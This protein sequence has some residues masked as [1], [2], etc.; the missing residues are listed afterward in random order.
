MNPVHPTHLLVPS[1]A[2]VLLVGVAASQKPPARVNSTPG[3]TNFTS[4]P[5]VAA[6]GDAVYVVWSD[7]RNSGMRI[8]T[9]DVYFNKSTDGGA[10]WLP[11]DIRLDTDPGRALS[12]SPQIAVEGDHVYVVWTDYRNG[13]SV[14][15]DVYFNRSVDGGVTWLAQD[16]RINTYAVWQ[17]G[18][19]DIASHAP[20]ICA[21]GD[22][23]FIA[24]LD[25][26]RPPSSFGDIFFNRSTDAGL[27]WMATDMRVDR[28]P[29]ATPEKVLNPTICCSGNRVYV[30]WNDLRNG[31]FDV[32]ANYSH[33]S[34]VTFAAQDVRVDTGPDLTTSQG[35]DMDCE[36]DKVVL[37]WWDDRSGGGND[38]YLNYSTDAAVTFQPSDIR[39][40]T[41]PPGSANSVWPQVE[42]SGDDV[43]VVWEDW[44]NGVV[45][46]TTPS[47]V[48]FS[49]SADCGATWLANDVQV[50]HVPVL[51][52]PD[53]SSARPQMCVRGDEVHVTWVDIRN[54]SSDV[55]FNRSFNKGVNW[56]SF[57]VRMD[58]GVPGAAASNEA[59]IA[60]SDRGVYVV[61]SDDRIALQQGTAGTDIFVNSPFGAWAY[62]AGLGGTGGMVPTLS[63]GG[64]PTPGRSF[65]VDVANGLGAAPG[66][67]ILGGQ[68]TSL[69]VSG[70]MLQVVPLLTLPLFLS[71]TPGVPGAGAFT[72]PVRV[73]NNE[74]FVGVPLYFQAL[75]LDVGATA[76]LSMTNGL[77]VWIG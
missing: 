24:W 5:Q 28:A 59:R 56:L 49:H 30:A 51:P 8:A 40:D 23:V 37:V 47:D 6:E 57:D 62:G 63:G 31:A 67:I 27:T 54:G 13:G 50:S 1:L 43:Y 14:N 70:G 64:Q 73:P 29:A 34:G 74:I 33:D 11:Q 12:L 53:H 3:G 61:W 20:A 10:T 21:N 45:A 36:G 2:V 19:P 69:P 58:G 42:I 55:Y 25:G 4:Q 46:P 39:I 72:L 76:G 17:T 48:F 77:E 68:P 18:M 22:H 65:T 52:G 32:Y 66:V 15:A 71:G 35:V 38:I 16:V 41:D 26:R 9:Q 7:S 44:R 75:M 60:C